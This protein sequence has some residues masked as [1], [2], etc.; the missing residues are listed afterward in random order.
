M[1]VADRRIKAI[2]QEY[3][4]PFSEVVR[5]M[6][7]QGWSRRATASILE[8]HPAT[9]NRY[10]KRYKLSNYFKNTMDLR[11]ECR[12]WGNQPERWR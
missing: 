5:G 7:I 8:L 12:S 1:T 6:A 10:V 2:S 3:N 11:R 9:F 4:E